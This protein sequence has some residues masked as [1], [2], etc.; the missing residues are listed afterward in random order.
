MSDELP[1]GTYEFELLEAAE[2]SLLLRNIVTGAEFWTEPPEDVYE[3]VKEHVG[4][5]L[6]IQVGW[7]N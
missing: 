6:R 1:D 4:Q 5:I 7:E 2:G 3:G